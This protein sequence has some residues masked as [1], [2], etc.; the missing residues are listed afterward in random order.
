MLVFLF[1]WIIIKVLRQTQIKISALNIYCKDCHTT[2]SVPS[3]FG[4]GALYSFFLVLRK[5]SL[6]SYC[7]VVWVLCGVFSCFCITPFGDFTCPQHQDTVPIIKCGTSHKRPPK[8]QCRGCLWEITHGNQTTTGLFRE[9]S[10]HIFFLEENLLHLISKLWYEWFQFV[11]E[12]SLY[13]FSGVVYSMNKEQVRGQTIRQVVNYKKLK[14]MKRV[15]FYER[16][17]FITE[18]WPGKFWYLNLIRGGHKDV[19]LYY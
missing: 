8:M 13:S 12:S 1:S 7:V 5:L 17:N 11:N 2:L 6:V 15:V 10:R 18:L 19:P 16:F 14:T 9:K 3:L 4:H